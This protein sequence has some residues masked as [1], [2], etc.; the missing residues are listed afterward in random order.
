MPVRNTGRLDWIGDLRKADQ[1]NP[2][3]GVVPEVEGEVQEHP[4][5]DEARGGGLHFPSVVPIEPNALT[6]QVLSH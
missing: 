6:R 4:R 3:L 5:D 1:V 2:S